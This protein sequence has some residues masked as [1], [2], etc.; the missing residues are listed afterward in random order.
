MVSKEAAGASP[1]LR[2]FACLISFLPA[3]DAFKN[4]PGFI[5]LLHWASLGESNYGLHVLPFMWRAHLPLACRLQSGCR[6]V[7][8]TLAGKG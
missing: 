7:C 8:A 2:L 1:L 4:L 6:V 3:A 5:I